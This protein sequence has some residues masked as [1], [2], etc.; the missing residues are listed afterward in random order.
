[1]QLRAQEGVGDD[2]DDVAKEQAELH[3][4][5][6]SNGGD[7]EIADVLTTEGG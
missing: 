3:S 4:R 2:T 1:M 7:T 6:C 5:V